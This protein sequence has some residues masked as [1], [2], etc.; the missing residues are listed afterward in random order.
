MSAATDAEILSFSVDLIEKHGGL[1]E[2]E[3][4]RVLALLPDRLAGDLGLPEEVQLG[5]DEVPLLYGSPLLDRLIGLATRDVPLVY[6]QIRMSYLKKAGFEQL[7]GQDIAFVDGQVRVGG[8]AETRT[9]YL[10]LACRYVALSDER[11]EGLVQ[12]GVHEG[13]GALVPGLVDSWEEMYP[14]FFP[15]GK[16]PPH[17]PAQ[18]EKAIEAAMRE[19][20]NLAGDTLADFFNSMKRRLQR[21]VKNT[22]EYYEALRAEMED[23]LSH[24]NLAETQRR[25]RL[26]KIADLPLE[27]ARKIEDLEQKH[28]VRATVS[29]CAAARL[30]VDVVQLMIEVKYRKLHRSVPVIWNPLTRRLDPLVCERCRRTTHRI[31]PV[32][33]DST[34]QL[35]CPFCAREKTR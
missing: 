5:S 32:A 10:A 18:M 19:A 35:L 30:L 15:A 16:V 26:D 7:L 28:H 12:V 14:E 33:Q 23:S 6:G 31:H 24:P 34:V 25:E 27:M 20:R 17:F 21:D 11:K 1:I 4:D 2:R 13:S 3:S 29:A 9:T 8:R 22:R